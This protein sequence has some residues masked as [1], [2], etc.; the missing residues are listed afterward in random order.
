MRFRRQVGRA[1][2][3]E[4]LAAAQVDGLEQAL[5][6]AVRT[7]RDRLALFHRAA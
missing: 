4:S 7:R 3:P 2:G 1:Y 6:T 5:V